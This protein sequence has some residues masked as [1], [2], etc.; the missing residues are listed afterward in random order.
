MVFPFVPR[1]SSCVFP[2]QVALG[3]PAAEHVDAARLLFGGKIIT[4]ST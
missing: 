1:T 4:Q 2:V 3:M